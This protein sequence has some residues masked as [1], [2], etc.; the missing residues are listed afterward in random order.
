MKKFLIVV[1]V[2][3]S[4]CLLAQDVQVPTPQ[5]RP[6]YHFTPIKNWTNDP[7]GLLYLNG[8]YELY[9]QQN[10][11]ENKW[12]HMSWGH[13][14]STDLIHWKHYDLAM[15]EGINDEDTTLRFSGSAVWD[16]NN[17]SGL[18][19]SGG[20]IVAIYTADQPHIKK[21]SQYIAYSNDGGMHF[22]NYQ[23]NPVIDLNKKDFRDPNVQWDEQLNKWLMVVS[24]P[25]E[26]EVQ[27]YSSP[28][29]KNWDLLS[30]FG[31]AGLK[32]GIWEC[33]FFI[34]LP[35]EGTDKSKWVLVNSFQDS[36]K[37]DYEEYY[38]GDFDGTTFTNDNPADKVLLIDHGDALYAAIP[39]NN[40]PQGQHTYIGWM[41]PPDKQETWPWKGQMSI[42]RDLSLR[43]TK[44][45][46][47]LFQNPAKV[48]KD[49]L[50]DFSKRMV[51][52]E[53]VKVVGADQDILNGQNISG[54]SYWI[55]AEFQVPEN[56]MAGFKI[57]EEKDRNG[58]VVAETVIGY[59]ASKNEVY[60]DRSRTGK[61]NI[62]Q[63][64][65]T[66]S[67][68]VSSN[69][70][71]IKFEILFDK[72]SLEVF[73]NDGEKVLT[74]NIYP[75]KNADLLSAFSFGGQ[76]MITSLKIWDMSQ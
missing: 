49:H 22:K 62:N 42:P 2:F 69:G 41:V 25:W 63:K 10:P 8:V 61:E 3:F 34:K 60:V 68:N 31:H 23:N 39:W 65:L 33:P 16:K 55:E 56:A 59:D 43:E 30:T 38:V 11:Y 64:K 29:L 5:W 17:T 28:D 50:A 20:C 18:C 71:K 52:L 13:A 21:E 9:N 48:I 45:G 27:F 37:N 47:R 57:A 35:V 15:P 54:N 73:V 67:M 44:D 6:V 58:N 75:D 4:T 72:S 46:I 66:Q 7:N 74:T 14:T 36:S 26:N 76:T 1:S 12:G 53:N 24:L 40:L 19:D 32:G 51:H 70:G